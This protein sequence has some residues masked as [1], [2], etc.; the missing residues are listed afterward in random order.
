MPIDP[1]IPTQVKQIE[2]PDPAV[3]L[4]NALK[5][6]SA[7]QDQQMQPERLK[8]LQQENEARGQ[9]NQQRQRGMDAQKALS[10]LISKHSIEGGDGL[11][12]VNEPAVE[13]GMAELGFA[14]HGLKWSADQRA[15][16]K[17]AIENRK[18]QLDVVDKQLKTIGALLTPVM[19][20]TDDAKAATMYNIQRGRAI[21]MGIGTEESLPKQ[22]DRNWVALQSKAALD[23]EK[24][25]ANAREEARL[26]QEII[27]KGPKNISEW[28][29][30]LAAAP[31][32][33]VLDSL[34]QHARSLGAPKEVLELLPN[35]WS[36]EAMQNFTTLAGPAHQKQLAEADQAV[37][38][39][40]AA[41]LQAAV[42][43][44]HFAKIL[45]SMPENLRQE[46]EG[47]VPVDQFDR[48]KSPALLRR[49]GMTAQQAEEAEQKD[50]DFTETKRHHLSDESVAR[51][52]AAVAQ[53]R[54]GEERMI[55]GM[56]YGPG[57]QE[58]WVQQ[59]LENPDSVKEMPAELRTAVGKALRSKTGLP[60]PT[61]LDA[62]TATQETAARNAL[63]SITA[64]TEALKNPEV[65]KQIG[66]IMG[67]LQNAEEKVGAAAGLSA[68]A[69]RLAQELRTRMRYFVFQEGKAVLGGRLPQKLMEQLEQSSATVKMNPSML[70]GALE[71]ARKNAESVMDN[72]E[73]KRFGGRM[74]QRSFRNATPEPDAIPGDV[75]TLL[76]DP[77]VAAGT[78]TLSDGSTW[79]K[80]ADGS[81]T[82]Q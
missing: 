10:N 54:L 29:A 16:K 52:D 48:T 35:E 20:E 21:E 46:V 36:P 15:G 43:P 70:A 45:A 73:R 62:Q 14:D 81:I 61:A 75:K 51:L 67:R 23:G 4:I 42:S 50:R 79:I 47:V 76:L 28:A 2:M 39:N 66:P 24:Q 11:F 58:Y 68:E 74:R 60:L 7:M 59:L 78:H 56:K 22:F 18:N 6:K 3:G 34:G 41:R 8:A 19:Q 40:Y 9:E 53:G 12:S 77:N 5:I 38:G 55:N 57:T 30:I 80:N 17:A 71:G 1:S 49:W 72:A 26:H 82:R 63:D 13:R 65:K 27:D 31:N 44:A 25:L 33:A 32:Q 69:E 64:I 37:R